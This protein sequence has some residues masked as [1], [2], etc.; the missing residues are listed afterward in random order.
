MLI[1]GLVVVLLAVA[2]GVYEVAGLRYV[3]QVN[4]A[5]S[6]LSEETKDK[7][8]QNL[9]Y[10]VEGETSSGL[11]IGVLANKLFIWGE[12]GIE[13]YQLAS[14]TV[15][16]YFDGC[17]DEV[18]GFISQEGSVT[19]PRFVTAEQEKWKESV[20]RGDFVG[21]F[22][23]KDGTKKAREVWVYNWWNFLPGPMEKLCA[24]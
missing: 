11:L 17:S 10:G 20:E 3:I 13:I 21:V 7:V 4:S 23:S 14:E 19:V 24:R 8:R 12:K 18:L 1:V 5:I 2:Y 9:Y 22:L 15:Y 6:Q 16:S